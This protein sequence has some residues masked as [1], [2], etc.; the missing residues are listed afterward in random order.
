MDGNKNMRSIGII[1]GGAWGTALAQ[2]LC[3]AGREVLLW[4]RDESV[5]AEINARH[6]NS[7]RLP[8]VKLDARLRATSDLGEAAAADILLLAAPAQHLRASALL[9]KPHLRAETHLAI[10]AK[11]IERTTELPMSGV[12]FETTGSLNLAVLSGPS[13][14]KDVALGLPT[15]VVLAAPDMKTASHLAAAIGH[16]NFRVYASADVIGVQTGGAVKNVLAIAAGIVAGRKLGASAQAALVTR[17]FH[18]LT[19]FGRKCGAKPATLT[20][21]SGLGDLMLTCNS[22]QSRNFAFGRR[23]GEGRS[24]SRALAEAGGTVE[25]VYTAKVVDRVAREVEPV[26][27]MPIASAV[28]GIVSGALSVDAAID[29][30]LSRPQR[31]ES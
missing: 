30:L 12:V 13:F 26:T 10:C 5:A 31:A 1:G 7:K 19:A 24:V 20:G 6:E 22:P 18:E 17:A 4:A 16:R 27:A 14:A 8:G 29:G 23:L 3:A 28:H 21:L 9:L 25:G 15:A 11:G 2:S